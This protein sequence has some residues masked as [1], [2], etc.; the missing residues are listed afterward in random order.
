MLQSVLAR[1]SQFAKHRIGRCARQHQS[2]RRRQ[3]LLTLNDIRLSPAVRQ[4]AAWYTSYAYSCCRNVDVVAHWFRAPAER[5]H[6]AERPAAI[7]FAVARVRAVVGPIAAR[8]FRHARQI[9]D[10]T[11]RPLFFSP[12]VERVRLYI[13]T[14]TCGVELSAAPSHTSTTCSPDFLRVVAVDCD[15]K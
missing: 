10:P 11:D 13:P 14:T 2:H 6:A 7:D 1:C 12:A 15:H 3:S 9:A 8:T 4:S 5:T